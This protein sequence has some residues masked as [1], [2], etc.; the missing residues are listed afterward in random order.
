M[1]KHPK[2]SK[3]YETDCRLRERSKMTKKYY[4]YGKMKSH[5]DELQEETNKCTALIL[6][7]KEKYVRCMNNKLNDPLAAPKSYCSILNRFLNDKKVPTIPPLL[8][9]SY[10]ITNFSEKAYL[11]ISFLQTKVRP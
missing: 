4:K 9:N 6:D 5:L 2:V 1:V 11:S 3:Y 7:A 8:V 10:I